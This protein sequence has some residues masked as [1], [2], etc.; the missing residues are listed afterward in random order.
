MLVKMEA[1]NDGVFWCA[2]GIGEDIFTQGETFEELIENVKEAV[3]VHFGDEEPAPD[4]LLLS[5]V[6]IPHATVAAG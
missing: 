2:R 4:I 1:Y 3:T 5:E 6:K